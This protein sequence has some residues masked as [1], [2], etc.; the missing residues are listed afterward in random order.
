MSNAREHILNLTM[1]E[2]VSLFKELYDDI[3]ECGMGGDTELAHV[4]DF[5]VSARSTLPPWRQAPWRWHGWLAD[6]AKDGRQ[7]A[8]WR[9]LPS[10]NC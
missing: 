10:F 3:A 5:E 7:R 4:N 2:K 8:P 6:D 1:P 9:C